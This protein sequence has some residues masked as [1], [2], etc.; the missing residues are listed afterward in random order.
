MSITQ[1][2][3]AGLPAPEVIEEVS[4]EDILS[5]SVDDLIARFPAISPVITLES[6]PARKLL[7][8]ASYREM[9]I[10]ARVNDA[11]RSQLLAF[12]AGA[13]LDHLAAFYDVVRLTGETDEALRT[14]T[15]LAIAS[16][17]TGGTADRYR[18]VALS[19]SV[20]VRDAIVWCD[21]GS[22]VVNV[23]VYSRAA[24]GVASQALLDTV[25]AALNAPTV[26]MVN[27]TIA[28]RS[29]VTSTQ[30]ITANVWLLPETPMSVFDGLPAQLRAAWEAEAGLGFD[31]TPSWMTARLMRPGV[32]KV[33]ILTP[34]EG[35]RAQPYEAIA[36]GTITLTYRGRDI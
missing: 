30:N 3:I 9:L 1:L 13:D 8:V 35:W 36:L 18:F 21:A 2:D 26:R 17:S 12:A 20:D 29:A 14:R 7:E 22:P 15:I 4:F 32:Q 24:G 28:V 19:A 10:R 31:L 11:A 23:A 6:E 33:A 34:L 25:S 5:L 27:D 16:R